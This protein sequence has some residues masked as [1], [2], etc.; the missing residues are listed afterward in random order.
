MPIYEYRCE[1]CGRVVEELR[2]AGDADLLLSCP[3]CGKPM[4]RVFSVPGGIRMGTGR[5]P[6][7]TCCGSTER[8]ERP[9]C[10]DGSCQRDAR[11]R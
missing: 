8:C 1:I 9:P 6:G 10:T 5:A 3:N 11:G 7:T 2:R 4:T